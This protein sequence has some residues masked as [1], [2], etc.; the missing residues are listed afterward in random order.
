MK[1]EF[2]RITHLDEIRTAIAGADEFI[3]AER[4]WGYV[5]NYLVNMKDTF[6]PVETVNDAIRR[7]ARGLIFDRDGSL[8]SR[9][10][11]KFFN[12]NER[13]ETQAHLIDLSQPHRILEKLDGCLAADTI[14]HTPYG[15]MTM[16]EVCSS[17]HDIPVMGYDHE[18]GKDVWAQVQ[19]T[20][21]KESIDNWYR[22]TLDDGRTIELTDNH[23][24]WCV[25]KEQYLTVLDLEDG[26][27]VRLLDK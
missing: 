8:I 18:T 11:H 5:V 14:V 25:N 15:E 26:D 19:G 2:P 1:Y 9:P 20:S 16:K 23:K 27:E 17:E 22:I 12:V 21:V 6:P 10:Y 3:I 7:E 24:V 4:D 13:D